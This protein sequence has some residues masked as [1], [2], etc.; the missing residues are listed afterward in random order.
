MFDAS[1]DLALKCQPSYFSVNFF[2]MDGLINQYIIWYLV[3]KLYTIKTF[4]GQNQKKVYT[5]LYLKVS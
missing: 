3:G 2:D 4:H 1:K 5:R